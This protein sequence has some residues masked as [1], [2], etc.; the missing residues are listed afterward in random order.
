MK[1]NEIKAALAQ[2]AQKVEPVTAPSVIS[3]KVEVET[4]TRVASNK[5]TATATSANHSSSVPVAS[6]QTTRKP[7]TKKSV[8]TTTATPAPVTK[9]IAP[10][11]TAPAQIEPKPLP[12]VEPETKPAAVAPKK[13]TTRK[14]KTANV[15]PIDGIEAVISKYLTAGVDYSVVPGCGPKPFLLLSGAQKLAAIYGFRSTCEIIHRVEN[16]ADCF[17]LYEVKT[18]IHDEAGNTVAQGY[19]S[20]NT[21]ERRYLKEFAGNLNVVLKMAVKR[22]FLASIILAT[23]ASGFSQDA[24]LVTD[25]MRKEAVG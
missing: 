1:I 12:M 7:S 11:V 15:I 2:M 9:D 24:D 23:H 13:T 17:V 3:P 19:G 6:Q 20:A 4:S 25:N 8:P 21:K 16:Y 14:T 18:T 5:N 22:S 10:V